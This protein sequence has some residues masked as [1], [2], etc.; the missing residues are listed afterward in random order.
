[1]TRIPLFLLLSAAFAFGADQPAAVGQFQGQTD[2][3]SSVRPGAAEFDAAKGAYTVTGG[4]LNMWANTD[5][6]HFV[7]KKLSGDFSITAEVR[8]TTGST[9]G[10][11]HRKAGLV[12]RQSLEPESPYVDVILH[13]S[14]M[15][16]LQFRATPG[17]TTSQV[18]TE[19]TAPAVL[20]LE[21]H[22]D[23]FEMWLSGAP[24]EAPHKVGST[25]LEL[26]DPIYV[27]LAVCAH[28]A[29]RM[30]TAVFSNVKVDPAPTP[31]SASK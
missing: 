3:G 13:G 25:G 10:N 12:V 18:E 7:W 22:G 2:I 9:D 5:A 14:G 31:A 28:D 4:G 11:P 23:V 21:R 20:R 15:T 16:S 30:E 8:I 26:H 17:G 19:V 29:G 1:M 27:G 6:F 24:G